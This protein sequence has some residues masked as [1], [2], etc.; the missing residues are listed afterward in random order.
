MWWILATWCVFCA[1]CLGSCAV[2]YQVAPDARGELPTAAMDA[3]ALRLVWGLPSWV[4]WGIA[5][6]WLAATTVTIVFAI[7][8]LKS[9]DDLPEEEADG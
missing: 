7:G 2:H 6:P 1:W 9:E 4:F 5:V 3:D 8:V